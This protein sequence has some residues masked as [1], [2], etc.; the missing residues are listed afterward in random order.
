MI[1]AAKKKKQRIVS[2]IGEDE[3]RM[4]QHHEGVDL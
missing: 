3:W 4:V 2:E 1:F